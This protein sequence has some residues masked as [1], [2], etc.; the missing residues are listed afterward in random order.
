[1]ISRYQLHQLQDDKLYFPP[2]DAVP[3]ARPSTLT[4]YPAVREALKRLAGIL[5]VDEMRRLNF[6]VDGEKRQ[7]REVVRELLAQKASA[8]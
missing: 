4:K 1:L 2:Y 7:P 6:A 3:V 8:R 5:S